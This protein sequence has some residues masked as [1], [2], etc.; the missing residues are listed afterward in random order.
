MGARNL[1]TQQLSMLG[2]YWCLLTQQLLI[3]C[4]CWDLLTQQLSMLGEY[5]DLLTQQLLII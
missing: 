3:T 2:E 5:W 1:Q 4:G